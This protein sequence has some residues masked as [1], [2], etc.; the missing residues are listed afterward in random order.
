MLS[1]QKNAP[2]QPQREAYQYMWESKLTSRDCF[3]M[4]LDT[5]PEERD[6]YKP[7]LVLLQLRIGEQFFQK[8]VQNSHQYDGHDMLAKHPDALR[9]STRIRVSHY[10]IVNQPGFVPSKQTL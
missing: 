8:F 5:I 9:E 6:Q 4:L 3:L 2:K 7:I 10:D 1:K